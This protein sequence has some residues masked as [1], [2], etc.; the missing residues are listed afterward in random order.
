MV[1]KKFTRIN[2]EDYELSVIQNNTAATLNLLTTNPF[3]GG[4]LLEGVVL[5]NGDTNVDHKLGRKPIG[6]IITRQSAA[7]DI[8]D[9]QDTNN[10]S[11]RTLTL[12]SS[13]IATVSI[14]V[15]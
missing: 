5:I 1:V 3:A 7:A 14:Y 11:D 13:A 12:N 4:H 9:K 8:Y 10:L 15:F 6:W 2:T